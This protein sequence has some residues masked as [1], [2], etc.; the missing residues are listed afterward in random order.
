MTK[1]KS[2]LPPHS[3][4]KA[5]RSERPPH[6]DAGPTPRRQ[7]QRRLAAV[8]SLATFLLRYQIP[9]PNHHSKSDVPE[10]HA[11]KEEEPVTPVKNARSPPVTNQSLSYTD[12]RPT[13]PAAVATAP[14]IPPMW[15]FG[16]DPFD[17]KYSNNE[18]V[19]DDDDNF[20]CP[21]PSIFGRSCGSITPSSPLVIQ[22][23]PSATQR[24]RE[25]N[26]FSAAALPTPASPT[27]SK[28][29]SSRSSCAFTTAH[30]RTSTAQSHTITEEHWP[31]REQL[32][33]VYG[34]ESESDDGRYKKKAWNRILALTNGVSGAHQHGVN[35]KSEGTAQYHA[36]LGRGEVRRLG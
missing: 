1:K 29:P 27:P 25:A 22:L 4:A 35:L 8:C 2:G 34:Y 15:N 13:P 33:N 14:P 19:D 6:L 31:T 11:V 30:S 9:P 12:G 36:A 28:R 10:V 7:P 26:V 3:K 20:D 5:Q 16:N 24:P 32:V 23:T 17:D 21:S 18:Y